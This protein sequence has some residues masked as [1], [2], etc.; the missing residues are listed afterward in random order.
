MKLIAFILY[1]WYLL[2]LNTFV[3]CTV[4]VK[5]KKERKKLRLLNYCGITDLVI[6]N[7]NFNKEINFKTMDVS[8]F[9]SIPLLER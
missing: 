5:L 6:T 1:C 8:Q 4:D 9:F 2:L 7:Y 3:S